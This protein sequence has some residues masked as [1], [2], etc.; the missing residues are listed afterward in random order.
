[1]Y[2]LK[3]L[4]MLVGLYL[5]HIKTYKNIHYIPIGNH[6]FVNYLGKNGSGKS[7]IIEALDIF[8]NANQEYS[9]N[10]SVVSYSKN[11]NFPFFVPI[12]L[13]DKTK[14]PNKTKENFSLLSDLFWNTEEKEITSINRR[15]GSE[16][17]EFFRLRETL[18]EYK[19]THFLIMLG[20]TINKDIC[21]PFFNNHE[22]FKEKIGYQDTTNITETALPDDDIGHNDENE[23]DEEDKFRKFLN[24]KFR[25]TLDAIKKTYSYV[26]IP[27]ESSIESFTKIET[28]GMQKIVGKTL[29]D[30]IM[31]LLNSTKFEDEI[32]AKLNNYVE[33]IEKKLDG[34]YYYDS[35]KQNKKYLKNT[36]LFYTIL[37]TYFKIRVLNKGKKTDGTSKKIGELSAGEKRQALLDLLYAFLTDGQEREKYTIIGIDEPENSLQANL[38]YEQF[39]KL[40]EISKNYQVLITTHWYGF[41]P[42]ISEGVGHF[43]NKNKEDRIEFESY[44]LYG[45]RSVVNKDLQENRR[46]LPHDYQLKSMN[47]LVQS[48]FYSIRKENPYN[49]L[50]CEGLSEK[51]YFDFFF[52][53][54]IKNK[55]LKILPLGGQKSVIS[56]YKYLALPITE[57]KDTPEFKGKIYCLI[58]TDDQISG[59]DIGDGTEALKIR[60]L[61]NEG[62]C[63][64]TK[65]AC[66]N[67][68]HHVKTEI[69]NVLN[70]IIF[71]EVMQKLTNEQKYKINDELD[72]QK[73]HKTDFSAS[74]N[75]YYINEFFAENDGENK[76]KFARKYIEILKSK[77]DIDDYIPNWVKE[78][79]NFYR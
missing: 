42:T 7:T 78:I 16:A 14:I 40:K 65:L 18:L 76:I 24:E 23:A 21:I 70:P 6:N 31:Q 38:C 15:S 2:F 44:E 67:N 59:S 50:I 43:L 11:S 25:G 32:N 57:M 77:T 4:D 73:T 37:D 36:D 53:E 29:K 47:D 79:K 72:L 35:T 66:L 1:M 20:E 13:I 68:M 39:E 54:E 34:E 71:K 9:I 28:I 58:D 55:K 48:I 33:N 60:R 56:L 27:V 19:E 52:E 64:A 49:W 51:I 3:E 12:F 41:L 10:K 75:N 69:E 8:F 26:Y 22:K 62:Q 30:E 74:F 61:L 45:Y 5:R 63:G 17:K 46:K